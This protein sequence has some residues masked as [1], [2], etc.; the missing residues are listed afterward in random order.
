P[1][2]TVDSF[3]YPMD[4]ATF[5]VIYQYGVPSSRYD[6]RYHAG[7]DWFGGRATTYGAP[8]RAIAK[9]R[10]TY[11]APLGWGL[12]KGV[13][14]IEHLLPDGTWWYSMYGHMEE[15][16][17]YT[18][19]SVFTC[20]DEG[21]II[22]A[23][24]QPRPA[25]H[26]HL[27]IRNFGPD[28]PGPGYWGTDPT[29][30]GWRNPS[31]FI[32]NWRA[33][34]SPAHVW[35]ADIADDSG[36]RF[37]AII[38]EDNVTIV[39][40][41]MRLK[42]LN[43]NGQVLWRYIIPE[44]LDVVGVMPYE[45]S[46]LIAAADGTMQRWELEGGFIE[47]W[48]V[49]STENTTAFTWQNLLIVHSSATQELIAYGPERGER[50]R[51]P[52]VTRPV[53]HAQTNQVLGVASVRGALTLIG[54]DG[55]VI[56]RATLASNAALAPAPDGGL[57]VHSRSALW[58]VDP[59]GGWQRLADSPDRAGSSSL[60]SLADG[61][62]LL[63][64]RRATTRTLYAYAPD[65]SPLW[66]AEFDGRGGEAD[67]L[68]LGERLLLVDGRGTI[69]LLD[70]ASGTAC[71]ALEVWG[72]RASAAWAGVGQDGILRVHIADQVIGLNISALLAS[73]PG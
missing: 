67:L 42:A 34:L 9:G 33:W 35:H 13:V 41:D 3:S 22:G 30:S 72:N 48:Q 47:Q 65:G 51:V 11:S 24:G 61:R 62:V 25:P 49:P 1:C 21:D 14:I 52:D 69:T 44:T 7:E 10:V 5:R 60:Y 59:A 38:R 15:V 6:G 50:W 4:P 45:D 37:P 57:Y 23:V 68:P 56:D 46:I 32:Q 28:S 20:V 66:A 40:D 19:P 31:K 39:F 43:P 53:S 2:G 26:L 18:F 12:D 27:E 55:R 73:C 8:V 16:G 63:Y 17:E 54:P 71:A 36:P 58:R 29:Y 64:A 70:G